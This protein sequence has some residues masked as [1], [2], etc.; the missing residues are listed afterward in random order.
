MEQ[1]DELA[2]VCAILNRG[3]LDGQDSPESLKRRH[4]RG[5]LH[6]LSY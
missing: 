5:G 4:A 1:A 6:G 3:V 2:D